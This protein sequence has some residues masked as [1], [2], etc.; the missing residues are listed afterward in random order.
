MESMCAKI[1]A[2]CVDMYVCQVCSWHVAGINNESFFP[3]FH[4]I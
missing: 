2:K 1:C 4:F 3:Y